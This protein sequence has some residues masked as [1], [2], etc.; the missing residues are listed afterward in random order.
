VTSGTSE[1]TVAALHE[2][3][4]VLRARPERLAHAARVARMAPTP[5]R[6]PGSSPPAVR[7]GSRR[8]GRHYPAWRDPILALLWTVR[9]PLVDEL[10]AR[11]EAL[12][13]S[14]GGAMMA[15]GAL[16]S[17]ANALASFS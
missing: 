16:S 1:R 12:R 2:R 13:W 17:N 8:G 4:V 3:E 5:S 14:E 11:L 10:P 15:L 7:S 6:G 9:L